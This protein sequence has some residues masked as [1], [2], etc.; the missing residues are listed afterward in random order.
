[1]SQ[2]HGIHFIIQNKTKDQL[3]SLNAAQSVSNF[4]LK[5]VIEKKL[6]V[7]SKGLRLYNPQTSD[8][9][10]TPRAGL[11][12]PRA[13]LGP[14]VW[15]PHQSRVPEVWGPCSLGTQ[16]SGNSPPGRGHQV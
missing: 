4:I 13:G 14:T 8:D 1:M 9:L 11:G 16:E 15:G 3:W 6:V 7:L 12:T 10:G 2:F 5:L